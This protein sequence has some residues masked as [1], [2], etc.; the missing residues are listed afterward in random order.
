MPVTKDSRA[1]TSTQEKYAQ[2][3]KE[4]LAIVYGAQKSHQYLYGKQVTV[5][6]DHKP[7]EG[8][9]NKPSVTKNHFASKR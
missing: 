1:L 4:T 9:L 7:L 2:I 3:E 5:Q 6:S 8:I